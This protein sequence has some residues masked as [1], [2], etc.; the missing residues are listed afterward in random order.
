MVNQGRLNQGA[1][2]FFKAERGS[3]PVQIDRTQSALDQEE[4]LVNWQEDW[5]MSL[6]P[7]IGGQGVFTVLLLLQLSLLMFEHFRR[8]V[9]S[10]N[11]KDLT[12]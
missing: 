12:W 9:P 10:F 6:D 3:N 1:F 8:R 4:L 7:M 5:A 2:V 11:L